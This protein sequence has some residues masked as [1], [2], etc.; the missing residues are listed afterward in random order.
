M[1]EVQGQHLG[2]VGCG[3]AEL[4][5]RHLGPDAPPDEH[6]VEAEAAQ[7]GGQVRDVAEGVGRVA[8]HHRPPVGARRADPEHQVADVRLTADQELVRKHVVGAGEEAA[9]AHQ[10]LDGRPAVG[11]HLQVVVDRDGLAVHHEVPV[12]RV[13][14]KKVEQRVHHADE[15]DAELLERCVPLAV[16]VRVGDDDER[17]AGGRGALPPVLC[18]GADLHA[19]ANQTGLVIAHTTSPRS[20]R[21]RK[22]RSSART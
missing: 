1:W 19:C 5:L 13:A 20:G 16:P 3:P 22:P 2:A 10:P 14:V 9:F 11:P 18:A 6:G 17:L 4:R 21:P 12:L 7:D 15:A 8:H